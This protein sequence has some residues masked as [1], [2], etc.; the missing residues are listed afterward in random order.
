MNHKISLL[1][2]TRG[3]PHLL[4]RLFKS[5]IDTTQDLS[6]VEII[7]CIDDDDPQSH[8]IDEP[9]LNIVKLIG[10]RSSMGDYNT[11]CLNRSTGDIIIL[12]NDDLTMETP[13][14]DRIV[15][16]F[17]LT[18]PDGI[19]M[20]YPNDT[21]GCGKM[22]TFPIMTRKTCDILSNPYPKEYDAL[23]IDQ[24]LLD[25][26]LRLRHL[27][28]NRMFYLE[29]VIFEHNHFIDGGVR[30]DASYSHKKRFSDSMAFLSLRYLRQISAQ[31][32]LSAIG[33]HPLPPQPSHS[34]LEKPPGNLLQAFL[35]Y[36]S[37][38]LLD[39][40]LP[41]RRRLILFMGFFKYFAA[42]KS[43]LSFLKRKSYEI[44]GCQ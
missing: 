27:G 36:S 44:Y 38:F 6:N 8:N 17:I 15:S 7:M 16:E 9:G 39:H 40:G 32:L 37:G 31:R 21:E 11:R 30:P 5:I 3:R 23:F 20:A 1:L 34:I 13:G 33:G 10:P 19:L 2:P 14:W 35:I 41:L 28:K 42:M 12:L 43:G 26:F 18:I 4:K 29:N 24:H 22:C 25:I